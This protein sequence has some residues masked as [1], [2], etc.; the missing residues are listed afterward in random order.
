MEKTLELFLHTTHMVAKDDMG[1]PSLFSRA[2]PPIM[3]AN[4]VS[5]SSFNSTDRYPSCYRLGPLA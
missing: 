3:P 2:G 4:I 5:S 1:R